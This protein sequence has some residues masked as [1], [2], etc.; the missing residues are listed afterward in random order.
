MCF[1]IFTTLFLCTVF[2]I[3]PSSFCRGNYKWVPAA[4]GSIPEYTVRSG[5]DYGG[6][7]LYAGRV[8]HDG[9]VIPAKIS[10]KIKYA[11]FSNNGY[12]Y[13]HREYEALVSNDTAWK[14]SSGGGVPPEALIIGTK[15]DG[16]PVYMGRTLMEG[17]ITPG[18]VDPQH[19]CLFVPYNGTERKFY[20]YEVLILLK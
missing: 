18:K 7:P 4:N 9:D 2:S 19:R 16:E 11:Y 14:L 13:R 1:H 8:K 10:T 3:I 6:G 17:T 12:E 20:T 15:F 5:T